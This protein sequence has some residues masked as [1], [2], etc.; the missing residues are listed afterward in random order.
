[1]IALFSALWGGLL[2]LGLN[3]PFLR[4]ALAQFYGPLMISGFLGTV[5][6][7]E[8]AVAIA[9]PWAYGVSLLSSAAAL[10]LILG[11]PQEVSTLLMILSSLTLV[12]VFVTVYL[13]QPTLFTLTMGVG[14]CLW[15]AGNIL[16]MIKMPVSRLVL[17]WGDFWF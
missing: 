4:P 10:T 9:K 14:A 6:G 13:R 15:I 12:L 1:M 5:I 16:W 17:W 8:R 3:L 11:F 2:R 7:L